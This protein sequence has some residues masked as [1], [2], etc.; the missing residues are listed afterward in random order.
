MFQTESADILPT[1][2]AHLCS[3]GEGESPI[4]SKH[5]LFCFMS[6]ILLQSKQTY[7]GLFFNL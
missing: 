2:V 1:D 6:L 3:E 5:L 4:Y 7:N